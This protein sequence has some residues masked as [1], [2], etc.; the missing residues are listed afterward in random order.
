MAWRVQLGGARG[1]GII[2]VAAV[3]GICA[4]VYLAGLVA[5]ERHRGYLAPVWGADGGAVY[6]VQRDTFGVVWG[7]GWEHFSPPAYAYVLSDR[8]SLRRLDPESRTVEVL[9]AFDG[10]PVAGRV[11]RHYRGRIFNGA[12]ARIAPAEG[13]VEFLI[14]MNVPK[15]P[16]S[17]TWA[18]AG[19]WAPDAPSGARWSMEWAGTTATEDAVLMNGVE[20][21]AVKGRESFPAAVLAVEA[22]GEARV[23]LKNDHFDDL[24][25][26]GVPPRQIAERSSRERIERVRDFTRAQEERGRGHYARL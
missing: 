4:F 24:Y 10:S 23:L 5:V 2:A 3:L 17:E 15:Q 21:I 7:M 6:L 13:G 25:P 22:D 16:R 19:T 8:F 1:L 26:D 11:T 9:E 14:R 18:L 20:L 12:S